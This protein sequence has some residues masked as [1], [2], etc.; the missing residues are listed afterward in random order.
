MS[1]FGGFL[2]FRYDS[3]LAGSA[4]VMPQNST[5]RSERSISL[6]GREVL[7]IG[8]GI[9]ACLSLRQFINHN[10][11]FPPPEFRSPVFIILKTIDDNAPCNEKI[12]IIN[13][14]C[15]SPDQSF[16]HRKAEI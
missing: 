4:D 9:A 15:G 14:I 2:T 11:S 16:R 8:T 12:N 5:M 1:F 3:A 7:R 13:R 10:G 6:D